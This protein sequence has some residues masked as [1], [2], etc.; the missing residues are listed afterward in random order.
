[1]F[2]GYGLRDEWGGEVYWVLGG[3]CEPGVMTVIVPHGSDNPSRVG[4]GNRGKDEGRDEG[5]DEGG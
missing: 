3:I 5:R 2:E 4:V 1:M